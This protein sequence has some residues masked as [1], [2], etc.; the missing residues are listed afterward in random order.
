M[1]VTK[2]GVIIFDGDDTLWRTQELY[3]FAKAEFEKLMKTQAFP[4]NNIIELLDEQDAKRVE[5]S[6]F[7]KT[8]FFE[9]MLIIYAF[10]C[11]K[12]NKKWDIS[13]ESKI[14]ELGFS[15]FTPPKLY[16]DAIPSIELLSK[17]FDLILFTNGDEEVQK[18]KIDSLGEKFKSHFSR[19]YISEMKNEHEFRKI[20]DDLKVPTEKVLVVGN[21]VKSDINP[22]LKLGFKAILIP[23]R[24]W[25]YEKST[26]IS[27]QVMIVHS[28][29]EATK[30]IM[31]E[32]EI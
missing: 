9:S 30:L 2:N 7:S 32:R 29:K 17:Y 16:D 1:V 11:G 27:D 24:T 6:K 23:R 8:R 15:V 21:S 12:H 4:E 3:D 18:R 22:A 10:L 14:R 19:I 26:L 28:L 25:E 20:R 31:E 5:I 13:I